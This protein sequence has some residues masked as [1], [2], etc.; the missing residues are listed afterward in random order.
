MGAGPS[1]DE[2][3][4]SQETRAEPSYQPQYK[5]ETSMEAKPSETKL[6]KVEKPAEVRNQVRVHEKAADARLL[7]DAKA[8]KVAEV[9]LPHNCEAILRDADFPIDRSTGLKRSTTAIAS[10]CLQR[11]YQSL[12]GKIQVTGA[13]LPYMKQVSMSDVWVD[14]AELLNV[15][16]LEI[17]G[18]FDTKM[19]S[20][21]ILYEVVFVIKLKDP[22]YGWAAPVTVSLVLP[23]GC[24]QE[25]KEK[26]QTKL[27]EQWI[28]IPVG[29]FI[30]S[31]ENVGEIQIG[32]Y[33]YDGGEW[34]RGLVIK[35]ITIRPKLKLALE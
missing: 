18:R 34:K 31:P 3:S 28:E 6:K 12:G 2:A 32:M 25:R 23:N 30:T 24:K 33:E 4:Q 22:A 5:K 16:W 9:K 14:V 29:E 27:R 17:Y 35:G 7:S 8:K 19:L 13:G 21:G 11:I 26:L 20:P 15:C 10:W 1:Q